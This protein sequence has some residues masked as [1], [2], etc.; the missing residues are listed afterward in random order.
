M[1]KNHAADPE[2]GCLT[3]SLLKSN[4]RSAALPTAWGFKIADKM[5]QWIFV[6]FHELKFKDQNHPECFYLLQ[7]R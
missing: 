1:T 3:K 4:G 6:W 7:S 2:K 5:R